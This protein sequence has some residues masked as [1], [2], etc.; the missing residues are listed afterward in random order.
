MRT[1]VI[2]PNTS[3]GCNYPEGEC[4]GICQISA[5]RMHQHDA[6]R[7][8]LAGQAATLRSQV[9]KLLAAADAFVASYEENDEEEWGREW[10]ELAE[11]FRSAIAY[12]RDVHPTSANPEEDSHGQI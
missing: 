9:A 11:T 6:V 3:G 12:A 7:L 10:R 2:C 5:N 8:A 4:L 1:T